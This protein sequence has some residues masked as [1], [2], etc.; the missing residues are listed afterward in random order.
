MQ[1][2]SY[3]G[4]G[5]TTEFN[6]NFPYFD[7]TN[8]IVTKNNQSATGYTIIGTSAGLDADIPYTGGKVVFDVAPTVLDNITIARSLP[9]TRTVDYQPTAKLEP[10]TLN[11]DMNYTIEIIKDLQDEI[12][13]LYSEYADIADKESTATLLA[14]IAA[15]SQQIT[16]LGDVTQIAKKSEIP[17]NATMSS[18]SMPATNTTVTAMFPTTLEVGTNYEFIAPSDGYGFF[19]SSGTSNVFMYVSSPTHGYTIGGLVVGA[20]TGGVIRGQLVIPK[21]AKV[22]AAVYNNNNT[23]FTASFIPSNG[24]I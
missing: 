8:I 22:A 9:I 16:D 20:S 23:N 17:T 2:V 18:M 6:F 4:D 13:S 5:S 11:Q 3:M 15:L 14:R 24:S 12:D 7:N 19:G 21:G 10:T 1:K